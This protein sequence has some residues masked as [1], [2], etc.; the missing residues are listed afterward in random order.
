M[1]ALFQTTPF[2]AGQILFDTDLNSRFREVTDNLVPQMIDDY[3]IAVS[4][5]RAQTNPAPGGV[6]NLATSLAGEIERLRFMI[7]AITGNTF[8]DQANVQNLKQAYMNS[9]MISR[10]SR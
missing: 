10:F 2:T 9:L 4:T 1:P 5:M 6:P 7:A 8:W 3:S